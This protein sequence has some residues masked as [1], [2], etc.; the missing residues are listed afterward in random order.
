MN[1]RR[2]MTGKNEVSVE[3]SGLLVETRIRAETESLAGLAEATGLL[4]RPI[5]CLIILPKPIWQNDGG[6]MILKAAAVSN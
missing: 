1:A 6:R 3:G 4:G 5:R 2:E